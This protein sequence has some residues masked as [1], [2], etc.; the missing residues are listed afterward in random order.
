[1]SDP[2]AGTVPFPWQV[3]TWQQLHARMQDERLPHALLISGV[4]GTGKTPF[5]RHF[6]QLALCHRPESG[7]P[8]GG[9]SSCTQFRAG[10]HPDYR[11]VT[12][13]EDKTVITIAQ[14]RELIADLSLTSQHGGRKVALV[15][16]ADAMNAASANALLKTLE[17]PGAGTLLILVS[18]RPARL[19]ATIRSRCQ[20]LR[21]LPP[22]SDLSMGWL[23]QHAPRK[24]WPVL[25]GLAGGGPLAAL[26][27]AASP[28]VEARL[29]MFRALFEIR[30]GRRNP[31]LCARDWSSKESDMMLTL[32]L[33]QSWVMDLVALASGA[34]DAVINKDALELL[35]STAQGIHL[36]GLHGMLGRLNEAVALANTSVNRQLL[37]ESL[38]SDWAEGLK[39]LEA[40][41]LAARGG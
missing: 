22:T 36:R 18:A 32:R 2:V 10:S 39:T 35:Q 25:L 4:P 17:E 12:I 16:P 41:P 19:P 23:N 27:L 28:Q 6:A 8:C 31:V 38:L 26:Q 5:A 11:Y 20:M 37:L 15:E 40:A 9:C 24:D 1:M 30:S 14:V 21:M 13:P 33:F 34:A 29:D 3:A 7:Q